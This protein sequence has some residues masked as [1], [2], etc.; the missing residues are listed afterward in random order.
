[1][2]AVAQLDHMTRL[3]TIV[4][5]L[6]LLGVGI[7]SYR[8]RSSAD[9]RTAKPYAQQF[10][11]ELQKDGR[12]AKVE[13]GVLELGSKGPLYVRGTVSSH[14]DATE[15]RR[16]FDALSCPV[17]VSWQIVVNTNQTGDVR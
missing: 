13:V 6:A 3:L 5:I 8:G 16:R 4:A 12:F 2:A 11:Q 7:W 15:L 14:L 17:G 9:A 1:M 10:A